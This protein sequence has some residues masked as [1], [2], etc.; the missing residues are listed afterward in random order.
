MSD[1]SVKLVD[2]RTGPECGRSP[3]NAHHWI[4]I[5]GRWFICKYCLNWTNQFQMS[6]PADDWLRLPDT[7]SEEELSDVLKRL[8][9]E[10]EP[11]V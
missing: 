5:K 11:D 9:I 1:E 8:K 7:T 2:Q 6:W 4:Q 3:T 10:E